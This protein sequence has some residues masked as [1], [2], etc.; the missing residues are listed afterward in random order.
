MDTEEVVRQKGEIRMKDNDFWKSL[1]DGSVMDFLDT[2]A[3]DVTAEEILEYLARIISKI[4][5][6]EHFKQPEHNEDQPRSIQD[7]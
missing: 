4:Y 1:E 2:S 6:A 7:E 3:D 5:L